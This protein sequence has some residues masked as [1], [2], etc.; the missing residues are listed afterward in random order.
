MYGIYRRSRAQIDAKDGHTSAAS[1]KV[2]RDGKHLQFKKER[3]ALKWIEE[4]DG[5][6]FTRKVSKEVK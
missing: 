5:E 6:F 2:K 1:A 3:D 4:N